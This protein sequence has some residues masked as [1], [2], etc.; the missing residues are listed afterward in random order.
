MTTSNNA[1]T[2]TPVEIPATWDVPMPEDLREELIEC[3][4]KAGFMTY[5]VQT[6]GIH[7]KTINSYIENREGKKGKLD[8]LKD[9][10]REYKILIGKE[11]AA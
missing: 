3:K 4:E 11:S 7:A 6:T 8:K 2:K 9:A 10:C 1:I 5:L